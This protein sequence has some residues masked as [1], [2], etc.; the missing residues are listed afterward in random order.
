MRRV[1]AHNFLGRHIALAH[2]DSFSRVPQS[3][4]CDCSRIWLYPALLN[5]SPGVPARGTHSATRPS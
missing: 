3:H 1:A 5:P 4:E 2:P